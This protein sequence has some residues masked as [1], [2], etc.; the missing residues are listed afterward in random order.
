MQRVW[1]ALKRHWRAIEI[2][3]TLLSIFE[4]WKVAASSA[5]AI[6]ISIGGVF[7][8]LP[9]YLTMFLGLSALAIGLVACNARLFRLP[10]GGGK[11]TDERLSQDADPYIPLKEA[12]TIFYEETRG[13]R[14]AEIA[15]R[16][17][18]G[19]VLGYYA[20]ALFD[21]NTTLYGNYPP[22][23]KLEAVPNEEYGRCGFSSDY[24][25]LRRWG[26]SQNLYEGL[27][28][29]RSDVDRRIA[30]LISAASA[31]HEVRLRDAL[32]WIIDNSDWGPGLGRD[33]FLDQ[34]AVV[35]RQAAKDGEIT[36]RGRRQIEG[37]HQD[38][39]FDL[40]WDDIDQSYWRTH[41]F[42]MAAV[43]DAEPH[44]ATKTQ[45]VS[46]GDMMAEALPHYAM[47][48]V[49]ND[50]LESRWPKASTSA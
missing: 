47:L 14:V 30:E 50:E 12:A 16:M 34:A 42:E 9:W 17:T 49:W 28:I 20:H 18:N 11:I 33:S 32:Y 43:M 45:T 24:N 2:A 7:G 35:L 38:G 8:G 40:T 31:P 3:T 5:L 25:A 27:Q 19:D 10:Q 6:V 39:E 1:Q 21:G 46:L 44:Y 37:Y 4:L 41:E 22:S 23:R 29:K 36:I 13:T 48:R 26:R 15:E